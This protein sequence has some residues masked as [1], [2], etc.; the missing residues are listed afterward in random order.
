[1]ILFKIL[2]T[3]IIGIT[4]IGNMTQNGITTNYFTN[5]KI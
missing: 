2:L 1:M 5:M 3:A 4:I